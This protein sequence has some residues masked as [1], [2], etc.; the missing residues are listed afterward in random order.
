MN[1][2]VSYEDGSSKIANSK[3]LWNI[4]ISFFAY[5]LLL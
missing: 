3:V 2:I 1:V 5:V 4:K